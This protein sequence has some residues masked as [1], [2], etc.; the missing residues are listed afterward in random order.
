MHADYLMFGGLSIDWVIAASSEGAPKVC[1]GNALYAAAAA[2][3]WTR[4]PIA[5][6]SR[7]GEDFPRTWI[8][9]FAVAGIDVSQIKLIPGEHGLKA[10]FLYDGSGHRVTFVPR[11]RFPMLGITSPEAME[12]HS[13][14]HPRQAR[15][16][17][18]PFEP[19]PDDIPAQFGSARGAV[20]LGMD[21]SK[22]AAIVSWLHER[23]IPIVLDSN[24]PAGLP[25]PASWKQVYGQ[26]DAL[27]PSEYEVQSICGHSNI[28]RALDELLTLGPKI[29][30]IKLGDRGSVVCEVNSRH[31]W[32]VPAYRTRALDPTGA[33]DA[34]CA[35]FLIGLIEAGSALEAALRGTV[36]ASFVV[37]GFT[38]FQVFDVTRADAEAR[39]ER[40]RPQVRTAAEPA[41]LADM[42]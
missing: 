13:T 30:A 32:L 21:F 17:E 12:D 6:V 34:Y 41:A 29:V 10:A 35:G 20:V 22:Q 5:V 4:D 39:L 15:R 18:L 26:V 8:D 42:V 33:G 28:P 9:R 31:A 14:F 36:A 40:L 1:G 3:I 38:P 37:E 27:L 16:S 25:L 2:R 7:M 23:N 19:E 11:E 24:V